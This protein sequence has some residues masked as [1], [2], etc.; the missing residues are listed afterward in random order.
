MSVS[1]EFTVPIVEERGE[2]EEKEESLMRRIF[3]VSRLSNCLQLL[4]LAPAAL[5]VRS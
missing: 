3:S 4:P 2:E 1:P 5:V